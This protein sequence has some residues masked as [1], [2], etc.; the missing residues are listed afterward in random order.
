MLFFK[1]VVNFILWH[2]GPFVDYKSYVVSVN[3]F[4]VMVVT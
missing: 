3:S 1:L 2:L 4:Q